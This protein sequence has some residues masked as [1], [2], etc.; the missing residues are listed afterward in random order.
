MPL[1]NMTKQ[2]L[3]ALIQ[4]RDAMAF[5]LTCHAR[6]YANFLSDVPCITGQEQAVVA[7]NYSD[8]IGVVVWEVC[9]DDCS[10]RVNLVAVSEGHRRQG[11][12]RSMWEE[13]LSE[14]SRRQGVKTVCVGVAVQNE[15]ARLAYS[16]LGL[17][18]TFSIYEMAL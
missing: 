14:M 16:S 15:E 7:Y 6:L 10:A 18:N 5:A 12:F 4:E 3:P 11:V 9:E 1:A 17:N 8:V 2:Y 13:A